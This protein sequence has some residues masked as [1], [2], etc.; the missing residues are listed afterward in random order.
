MN[1]LNGKVGIVTGS[2][3][4]IGKAIA[5]KLSHMGASI[6]VNSSKSEKLGNEVSESIS[7][8]KYFKADISDR[9]D[10]EKLVQFTIETFGGLDIL[11]NNAGITRL[12]AHNDIKKADVDVWKEIFDVNVFGTWQMCSSAIKY[13]EQSSNGV[14][15]NISSIA[16][17]RPTGSSIPYATSKAAVNHMTRLLAKTLGPKVRVN[18]V[19]P[20]LIDTPWTQDWDIVRQIV[21]EQAPL[22]RSGK[23]EDVASIVAGLIAADY[24]TGEVVLADGGLSLNS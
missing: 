18:A 20:G 24:V 9:V 5:E 3:S 16:S 4:G 12:I 23:P 22:K 19:A 11:V 1:D 8:S 7:N 2:S 17:I 6:V 14:I 15:I 21:S 10:C 13:L